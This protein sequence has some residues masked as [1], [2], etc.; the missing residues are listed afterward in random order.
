[1]DEASFTHKM[2]I[3]DQARALRAVAWRE[4]RE[5]FGFTGKVTKAQEEM[6][7]TLRQQ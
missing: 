3:F 2:N 5:K 1:M 4:P 6:L 7:L